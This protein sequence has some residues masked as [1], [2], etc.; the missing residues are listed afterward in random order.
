MILSDHCES[1]KL[2]GPEIVGHS[3]DDRAEGPLFSRVLDLSVYPQALN[4]QR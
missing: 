1:H 2:R 4:N 3:L